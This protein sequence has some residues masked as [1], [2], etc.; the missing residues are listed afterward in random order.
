MYQFLRQPQRMCLS[1][2]VF[3]ILFSIFNSFHVEN[4]F[5]PHE[6]TFQKSLFII[7]YLILYSLPYENSKILL[8]ILAQA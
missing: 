2:T 6:K 1:I 5:S 8:R 3:M 7:Y 4:V